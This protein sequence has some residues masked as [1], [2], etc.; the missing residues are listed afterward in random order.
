MKKKI[1]SGAALIL[2]IGAMAWA[3]GGQS[4]KKFDPFKHEARQLSFWQKYKF[5]ELAVED[6][7]FEIPNELEVRFIS[8][9]VIR[10]QI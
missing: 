8:T 2:V 4:R 7:I 3:I 5:N 9:E 10:R 1:I 6:R